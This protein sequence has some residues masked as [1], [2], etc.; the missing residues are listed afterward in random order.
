MRHPTCLALRGGVL[1]GSVAV[2]VLGLIFG[3]TGPRAGEPPSVIAGLPPE[4]PADWKLG[5]QA[6][7]ALQQDKTLQSVNIGVTIRGGTATLWGPLPDAETVR[8]AQA[9]LKR[10][11]GIEKVIDDTRIVPPVDPLP[12]QVAD[13]RR[14]QGVKTEPNG[15][16]PSSVTTA[17][18]TSSRPADLANIAPARPSIDPAPAVLLRPMLAAQAPDFD[19]LW[20]ALRLKDA[21]FRD[22]TLENQRG[23]L[24]INGT[25]PRIADAWELAEKLADFPGVVQVLLDK[26]QAQ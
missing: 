17:K 25:V 16:A 24:R 20:N 9:C 3:G 19:H 6:R 22:V 21:R 13:A 18:V 4:S 5:L 2:F 1:Q 14:S 12:A 7:S 10:I 8:A 15:P 11:K 26:V 23:V